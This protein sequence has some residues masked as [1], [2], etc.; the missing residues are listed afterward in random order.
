MN[1]IKTQVEILLALDALNFNAGDWNPDSIERH[2]RE[3]I[4]LA[5]KHLQNINDESFTD[6]QK[7]IDR[8][9]QLEQDAAMLDW[10]AD[11]NNPIGNVQLPTECVIDNIDSMR[12]AIQCAM[13]L[14]PEQ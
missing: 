9:R 7:I 14:E 10:L 5:R 11:R 8:N 6:A 13:K 12:A 3:Q 4:A 2:Q 1:T